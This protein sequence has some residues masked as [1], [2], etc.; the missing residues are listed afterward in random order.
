MG[1]RG[2]KHIALLL[3]PLIPRLRGKREAIALEET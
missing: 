1:P 2:G 3:S